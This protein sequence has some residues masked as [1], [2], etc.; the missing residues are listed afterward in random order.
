MKFKLFILCPFPK[1]PLWLNYRRTKSQAP[2]HY[3]PLTNQ[4]SGPPATSNPRIP[5]KRLSLEEMVVRR[6]KGLYYHCDEKWVVYY[7]SKPRLH[8]FIA[9]DDKPS[10]LD[11]SLR[12]DSPTVVPSLEKILNDH[13]Q[14]SL[15][16]LSGIL[17]LETFHIYGQISHHRVMILNDSG[18]TY[19]FIQA[20]VAK[21]L[22]FPTSSTPALQVM[23]GNGNL[24]D[25]GTTCPKVPLTVQGH[26]FT[27][28]LFQLPLCGIVIV[29]GVQWLKNLGP[30]T[31]N[32]TTH[33]FL[34]PTW[35][36]PSPF[37]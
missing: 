22:N 33:H 2:F 10:T 16:V 25:Y 32:Y 12:I 11:H 6:D 15:S 27:L 29:L 21:F 14:I 4:P 26:H 37:T 36:N 18:S 23:V 20:R 35:A 17:V 7:C 19:N 34:F 3:P 24:L 28:D 8:L 9:D 5:V 1:R 13:P 31:T 30:V